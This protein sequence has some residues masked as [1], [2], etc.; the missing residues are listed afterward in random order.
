MARRMVVIEKAKVFIK[1]HHPNSCFNFHY[2]RY[3]ER[4]LV[5]L[6]NKAHLNLWKRNLCPGEVLQDTNEYGNEHELIWEHFS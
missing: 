5:A 3:G 4:D 6:I 2:T 1:H